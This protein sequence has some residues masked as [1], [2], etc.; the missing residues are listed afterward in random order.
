MAVKMD[1]GGLLSRPFIQSQ[2]T[3]RLAYSVLLA[4]CFD[5]NFCAV[6]PDN[7]G[8]NGEGNGIASPLDC[9]FEGDNTSSLSTCCWQSPPS[10]GSLAMASLQVQVPLPS[11]PGPP[12]PKSGRS[13]LVCQTVPGCGSVATG[14]RL[15]CADGG[16][17]GSGAD[18]L[19]ILRVLLQHWRARADSQVGGLE[20]GAE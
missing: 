5:G 20:E 9:S 14:V 3:V 18:H 17:G 11:P 12:Q 13:P 10:N 16:W 15:C 2:I 19:G 1:K 4:I 6:S 7:Q 8:E